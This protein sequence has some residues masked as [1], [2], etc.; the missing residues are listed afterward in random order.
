MHV[1]LVCTGT[2]QCKHG[3]KANWVYQENMIHIRNRK[4]GIK[5]KLETL[6]ICIN[7]NYRINQFQWLLSTYVQ[8]TVVENPTITM[9][10]LPKAA[11]TGAGTFIYLFIHLGYTK[12]SNILP[13][14]GGWR[15]VSQISL[16]VHTIKSK[17]LQNIQHT[18]P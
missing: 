17:S 18:E 6:N 5:T 15:L 10:N 8:Q 3:G 1:L 7:R 9:I 2:E 14:S 13:H 16:L 12:L 4:K 11:L